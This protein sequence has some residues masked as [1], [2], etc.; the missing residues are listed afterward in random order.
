VEDQRQAVRL[1]RQ[2]RARPACLCGPAGRR[3]VDGSP[4]LTGRKARV[5]RDCRDR[6]GRAHQ[7]QPAGVVELRAGAGVRQGKQRA[8]QRAAGPRLQERR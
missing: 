8:V 7:D 5:A 1:D 4:P 6:R 3:R 2:G